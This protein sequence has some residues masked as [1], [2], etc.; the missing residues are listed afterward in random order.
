M[1]IAGRLILSASLPLLVAPAPALAQ[2]V[3]AQ[4]TQ[5]Q[6]SAHDRLFR[7]FK[8]SD[9]AYLKRNPMQAILRGD[10]RYANRLGDMITEEGGDFIIDLAK[11]HDVEPA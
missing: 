4:T 11:F 8:D 2:A 10:M 7:L 6:Q 9:E 1:N 5:A 3:T